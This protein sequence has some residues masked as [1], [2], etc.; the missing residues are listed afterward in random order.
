MFMKLEHLPNLWVHSTSSRSGSGHT[1]GR[2]NNRVVFEFES[3]LKVAEIVEDSLL[4]NKTLSQ[5]KVRS[6]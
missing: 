6:S 1:I 4:D 2:N 3:R 5:I